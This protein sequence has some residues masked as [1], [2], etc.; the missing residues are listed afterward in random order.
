MKEDVF[1]AAMG[2]EEGG[3]V[4][5]FELG[6]SEGGDGAGA[7]NFDAVDGGAGSGLVE[8][9]DDGVDFWEFRHFRFLLGQVSGKFCFEYGDEFG[10]HEIVV[11]GDV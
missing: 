7:L 5:G 8:A 6:G 2:R 4:E 1:G 3:A 11:V 9:A 10:V